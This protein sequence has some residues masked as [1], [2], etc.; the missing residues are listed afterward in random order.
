MHDSIRG[1]ATRGHHHVDDTLRNTFAE[2][3]ILPRVVAQLFAARFDKQLVA[4][5]A[6]GARQRPRGARVTIGVGGRAA[7]ARGSA[8]P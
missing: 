4:G 1:M 5:V 7:Q 6:P 2:A 3:S 8:E